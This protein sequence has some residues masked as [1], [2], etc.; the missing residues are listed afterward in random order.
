MEAIGNSPLLEVAISLVFV[1]LLASALSA[2]IVEVV[3]S[4]LG[5]RAKH[6][7]RE[8]GKVLEDHGA[9]G[10]DAAVIE[11][12]RLA[13]TLPPPPPAL[14]AFIRAV[15]GVTADSVK[16]VR[17]LHPAVA[18]HALTAV[19]TQSQ[20]A[21]TELGQL[22][23]LLPPSVTG[24]PVKLQTWLGGW[25]DG[26]MD[27]VS[28]MYR[29]KVR[30]W[31]AVAS[32]FVVGLMGLDSIGLAQSLLDEPLERAVITAEAVRVVGGGDQTAIDLCDQDDLKARVT[33]LREEAAGLGALD[34]SVWQRPLPR[35]WGGWGLLVV[36]FLLSWAAV[37]AGAPFWFG[38]LKRLMGV[39]SL[40]TKAPE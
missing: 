8:L 36:G 15:P 31:A 37:T 17:H 1:W 18:A 14:D 16:R 2:G 22:T 35:T 20:F 21:S 33:C 4:A 32:L 27:D 12:A 23:T 29:S 6:L 25:F 40:T 34:V 5:F 39:R 24:N 7:W 28:R 38:V 30:W 13:Q 26:R 9:A 10:R 11:A 3:A 19:A